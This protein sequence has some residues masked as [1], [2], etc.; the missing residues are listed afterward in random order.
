VDIGGGHGILL[1][2]ILQ[3]YPDLQ[4]VLYELPHVAEG[5]REPVAQSGVADRLEILGGNC[6][7][8]M[9]EGADAYITKSFIHS[10]DDDTAVTILKNINRAMPADGRVLVCEMVLPPGNQPHFGKLFDI[11]MMTQSDSGRDRT[12]EEFRAL[13][14]A[15]GLK[16][17][18]VVP[19]MTPV[20]VIEGV[21][22]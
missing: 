16:L 21:R 4:G 12:E 15:A 20:S 3:K 13:F 2:K 11:E 19:T 5:A 9:P 18:R 17:R 1:V 14:E 8:R 6:F 10:F 7:E 22:A